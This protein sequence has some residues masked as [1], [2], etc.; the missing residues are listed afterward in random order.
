MHIV[1]R[2][3]FPT[4]YGASHVQE[5]LR[6]EEGRGEGGFFLTCHQ[7]RSLRLAL[8]RAFITGMSFSSVDSRRSDSW[9]ALAGTEW[10]RDV[11]IF[12]SASSLVFCGTSERRRNRSRSRPVRHQNTCFRRNTQPLRGAPPD[13][14]TYPVR[15]LVERVRKSRRRVEGTEKNKRASRARVPCFFACCEP[16]YKHIVWF[17]SS[18]SQNIFFYYN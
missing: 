12:C 11:M 2:P 16:S 6:R 13:L 18:I 8:V 4:V 3:L 10:D 15:V 1:S 7:C 14:L 9:V 17:S 5:R